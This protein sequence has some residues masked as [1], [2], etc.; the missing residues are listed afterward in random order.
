MGENKGLETVPY[1]NTENCD[2]KCVVGNGN[3]FGKSI[4]YFM[5]WF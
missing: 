3:S 5:H 2:V 4:G 1:K